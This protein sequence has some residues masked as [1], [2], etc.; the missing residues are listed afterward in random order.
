MPSPAFTYSARTSPARAS[1]AP[2][3]SPGAASRTHTA[4]PRNWLGTRVW[5]V[6]AD[7][8]RSGAVAAAAARS[9]LRDGKRTA[10]IVVRAR[11][12][13]RRYGNGCGEQQLTG[14][15]AEK[16]TE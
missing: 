9:D 12:H 1:R 10:P 6:E 14:D 15:S 2:P 16:G 13:R 3:D 7:A 11:A 5:A 4:V 8:D